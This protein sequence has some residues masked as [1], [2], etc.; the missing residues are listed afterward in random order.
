MS[1]YPALT[2][3]DRRA[4][5]DRLVAAYLTGLS[6]RAVAERFGLSDGWVRSV[7]RDAGVARR[8]GRRAA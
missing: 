8:P 1:R 5:H 4:R 6:S 3:N 7:L 2:F